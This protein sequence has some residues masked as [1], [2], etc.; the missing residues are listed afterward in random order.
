LLSLV[1]KM[2]ILWFSNYLEPSVRQIASTMVCYAVAV[3]C[4]VLVNQALFGFIFDQLLTGKGNRGLGWN[5]QDISVQSLPLL[6]PYF[7]VQLSF[8]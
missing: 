3:F 4:A 2:G 5:R 1:W 8:G 7:S 6:G